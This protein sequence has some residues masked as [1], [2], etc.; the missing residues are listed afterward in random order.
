VPYEFRDEYRLVV[1]RTGGKAN[2]ELR[3]SDL[4]L[5]NELYFPL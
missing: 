2:R 1:N 3:N 4:I 5:L